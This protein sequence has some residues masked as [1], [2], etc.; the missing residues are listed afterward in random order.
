MSILNFRGSIYCLRC[1]GGQFRY[2]PDKK[3]TLI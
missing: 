1:S 2:I 3:R